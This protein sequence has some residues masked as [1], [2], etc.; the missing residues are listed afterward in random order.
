MGTPDAI[1]DHP[2]TAYRSEFPIFNHAVYLNSCSLGALGTR[3]RQR[4]IEFLDTWERRGASAWYDV[5]WES[6]IELRRGYASIIN[7]TPEEISLHASVSA[8]AAAAGSALDYSKRPR[9]VI[10]S[11]DF[12][13]IGHQWLAKQDQ[14]VE[15]VM[16]ESPDG[17]TV[18]LESLARAVDDRTALVATSH[19][20]FT[21]GA[22]QD[23]RQVARI[24]H[25][26][27]AL[28]LID[29]YQSVGQFPVDVKAVEADFLIAGG[30]KWLLGGPGI[31]FMYVADRISETLAPSIAG[32]FSQERQFDFDVR[33]LE[34]H[35]DARKFEQG[36]PALTAVHTQLG[37]LEIILEIGV[38]RIR[39]VT[40]E[41]VEDLVGGLRDAGMA[42]R[43]AGTREE[44]T[45]IV[46]VPHEDP[47]AA[48]RSLADSSIIVDARPGHVR[49]SPFFYNTWDDNARVVEALARTF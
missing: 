6:L 13:T 3:S 41:L 19:V 43:V 32:W 20:F 35:T 2:L 8:A 1:T 4:T 7:S 22:V 47:Q 27:G 30:L 25:D 39:A 44:R 40:S 45:A 23:I 29:A 16:V 48:V 18:P 9:V 37:G 28:C 33:H 17:I 24:A 5:W 11:L 21:T 38:P 46:M 31:V 15:V 26:A 14:G 42:P 36:T 49:I 12:P 34:F 10:T